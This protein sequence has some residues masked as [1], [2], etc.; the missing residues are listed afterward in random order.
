[1]N[2]IF[3]LPGFIYRGK[4]TKHFFIKKKNTNVFPETPLR[5]HGIQLKK[6]LYNTCLFTMI[7]ICKLK[8]F[9]SLV[10]LTT[11]INER[12]HSQAKQGEVGNHL[13]EKKTKQKQKSNLNH[14]MPHPFFSM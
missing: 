2:K 11:K 4:S 3:L 5:L 6:Q 12:F 1:M 9:S 13:Q 8:D 14:P 7:F 10:W